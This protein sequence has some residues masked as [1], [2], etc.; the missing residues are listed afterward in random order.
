LRR[1]VL[2]GPPLSDRF[3]NWSKHV[4]TLDLPEDETVRLLW[5]MTLGWRTAFTGDVGDPFLR[6]GTI[7]YFSSHIM[8]LYPILGRSK[9]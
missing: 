3:L 7:V 4:L 9:M 8:D 5:A 1:P 6:A 2:P